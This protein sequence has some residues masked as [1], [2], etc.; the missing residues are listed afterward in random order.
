[1]V[2]QLLLANSAGCINLVTENEER[3]SR[4]LL[5]RQESVK[6]SFRLGETLKVG[7]IDEEDDTRDLGEIITPE[8][9]S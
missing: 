5:N 9:T 8:T 7:T 3:D 4:E 6:F 1:M 2:P